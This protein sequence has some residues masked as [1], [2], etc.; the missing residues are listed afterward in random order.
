MRIT[1]VDIYLLQHVGESV[2]VYAYHPVV[3]R[4]NTDEGISGLGEAGISCGI[5]ENGVAGMLRD[6]S[7]LVIG[8][9]PMNNEVHWETFHNRCYGHFSGG[10]V[11]FYS[12]VSALDTAMLDIKG[13]ALGVPI[14]VLLGGKHNDH[15]GCYLSQ[16]QCGFDGD[17]TTKAHPEEFGEVAARIRD[18]G[19]KAAKFCL[20]NVDENGEPIPYKE[21]RG[22]LTHD[23]K[24]MITRRLEAIRNSVGDE[25][26]IILEDLC[27]TDLTSAIQIA[28]IA[29]TYDCL[30]LEE[31]LTNFNPE[32]YPVLNQKAAIPLSAGERLHTRWEFEPI[33][34][35]HGIAIAQPDASNTGG[36]SEAKKIADLA[37]I[38]DVR[39]QCHVAG[40]AIADAMAMQ[41]EA[42]IPNFYI[43]ETYFLAG[44]DENIAL[45]KY[46]HHPVDGK[47]TVPDL[48]GLGQE[49]TEPAMQNALEHIVIQ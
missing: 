42:A 30:F 6:L 27:A 43:H 29:K 24:A 13:K 9:D 48:P 33:F 36:I 21:L 17:Y 47:I 12:A 34:R 14:Y 49:L 8:K 26:E 18:A 35:N 28:E 2:S 25:L 22:P 32:M 41:V 23:M 46:N 38:Y 3:C 45:C 7:T 16:A 15:L 20:T 40:T 11:G 5:G 4:V 31:A 39:V 37:Q 19:Y 44:C 10:G 1:S